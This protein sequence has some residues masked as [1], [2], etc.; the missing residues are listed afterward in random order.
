MRD[1]APAEKIY[2]YETD[3]QW[4]RLEG[5]EEEIDP[6]D[7]KALLK[8]INEL[9]EA[10]AG[11]IIE[12]L[13]RRLEGY[14]CFP[15]EL[16]EITQ[17]CSSNSGLNYAVAKPVLKSWWEE[18]WT[19][20]DQEA[21]KNLKAYLAGY[22]EDKE[23][24]ELLLLACDIQKD[25]YAH[26]KKEDLWTALYFIRESIRM[27]ERAMRTQVGPILLEMNEIKDSQ[28]VLN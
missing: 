14:S 28:D 12:S 25:W 27:K 2:I 20:Q 23:Y 13:C 10:V 7:W 24:L 17:E 11:R 22:E 1:M 26:L 16:M 19:R 6:E 8:D 3:I 9:N 5:R 15:R 18:V 21:F 4:E